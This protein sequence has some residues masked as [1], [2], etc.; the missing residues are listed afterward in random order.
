MVIGQSIC[1]FHFIEQLSRYGDEHR[2]ERRETERLYYI[3]FKAIAH[4]RY[5][6]NPAP[7]QP[8]GSSTAS[9]SKSKAAAG[10]TAKTP[11]KTPASGG[12]ILPGIDLTANIT[13]GKMITDKF[14]FDNVKGS[15]SVSQGIITLQNFS[16]NAFSGS[17]V[18][19]G[20]LDLRDTLKRPFDLALILPTW[21]FISFLPKFSRSAIP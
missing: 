4:S 8:A 16:L 21:M 7:A 13:V 9:V 12:M 10:E 17:I 5:Y 14:E 20:T 11:A 19:K 15:M 1:P 18:T 3:D 2:R 6:D